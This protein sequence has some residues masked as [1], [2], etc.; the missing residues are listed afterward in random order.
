MLA[1]CVVYGKVLTTCVVLNVRFV[2]PS[3]V[4]CRVDFVPGLRIVYGVRIR[5]SRPPTSASSLCCLYASWGP[6]VKG[7]RT[8]LSL[9]F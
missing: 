1:T 8:H 4:C 6:A 2:P 5:A 3:G 7:P 9:A